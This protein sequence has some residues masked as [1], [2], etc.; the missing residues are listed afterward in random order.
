MAGEIPGR[1][2]RATRQ[3]DSRRDRVRRGVAA[4]ERFDDEAFEDLILDRL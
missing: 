1:K 2:Q 4:A 3:P